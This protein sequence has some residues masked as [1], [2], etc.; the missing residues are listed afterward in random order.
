M[1][2]VHYKGSLSYRLNLQPRLAHGLFAPDFTLTVSQ[3]FAH[4][5]NF[6]LMRDSDDM[7]PASEM[8]MCAFAVQCTLKV[9]V[10]D[11]ALSIAYDRYK[12][13]FILKTPKEHA[14]DKSTQ[15]AWQWTSCIQ[16]CCRYTMLYLSTSTAAGRFK[17]GHHTANVMSITEGLASTECHVL[18]L[19]EWFR[20]LGAKSPSQ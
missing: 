19:P 8:P 3:G 2:D 12:N 7:A 13:E 5:V 14:E 18:S 20:P 4:P 6:H 10:K 16:D 17:A 9:T 15:Y 1:P 11:Q